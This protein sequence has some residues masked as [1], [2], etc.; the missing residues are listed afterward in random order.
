M[1]I[2]RAIFPPE[3]NGL[4]FLFILSFGDFVLRTDQVDFLKW[5]VLEFFHKVLVFKSLLECYFP[6]LPFYEFVLLDD[7]CKYKNLIFGFKA[8]YIFFLRLFDKFHSDVLV[9]DNFVLGELFFKRTNES[10][11]CL[12][13]RLLG[14]DLFCVEQLSSCILHFIFIYWLLII[15]FAE[16]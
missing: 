7:L 1:L 4:A 10:V 6:N 12:R 2:K 13:V 15:K 5:L 9:D 8:W 16:L 14:L 3:N 11:E